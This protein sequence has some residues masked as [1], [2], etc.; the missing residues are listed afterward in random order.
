MKH[1]YA[2]THADT[3]AYARDNNKNHAY[4]GTIE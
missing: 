2:G 3:Y 1:A 4:A